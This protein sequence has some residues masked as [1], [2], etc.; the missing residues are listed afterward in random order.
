[1]NNIKNSSNT[2]QTLLKIIRAE[3]LGNYSWDSSDSGV[4]DGYGVNQWGTSENYE[5]ADLMRELN[6]DYL[7]N[8]TVATPGNWYSGGNNAKS[9]SKPTT[10]ISG[11][12]QNQIESVVWNLGS[13]SNDNGSYDSSYLSNI[14][15]STSYA[16][17]RANTN[18]KT[19]TSGYYC[20]DEVTRTPTWTG[21]VALMYPSD[22][23]YA[24]SGGTT[25]NRQTCLTA[26]MYN[27]RDSSVTDCKNN[28]WLTDSSYYQ[29]I[30]SPSANSS[31]AY[32][33]FYVGTSG[34]VST[35]GASTAGGVH[36]V[37]FLKSSISITGG[38]GSS[39]NPYTIG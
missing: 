23:G 12:A 33:V 15:P 1:M 10:T 20:N 2:N 3:S 26:S 9:K 34:Y 16:R 13:P 28:D 24:T 36:P 31:N 30:L 18:G 14:T 37:V 8:I 32:R 11:A 5:G 6:T 4:N 21:K 7:G 27:W 25:T 22:Y 39:T 38:D 17:E 29:W 35:D 19:C